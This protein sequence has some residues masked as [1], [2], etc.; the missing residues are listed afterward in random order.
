M[1]WSST[2]RIYATIEER[3][4]ATPTIILPPL[5]ANGQAYTDQ[6]RGMFLHWTF[7]TFTGT[8]F[9]DPTVWPLDTFSPTG[10]NIPQ[11]ASV[12]ANFGC[13][14]AVLTIKHLEG[15]CLWPTTTTTRGIANTTWYA[16]NGS[17]DIVQQYVTAFRAAG[18]LPFYYFTINDTAWVAAHPGWT[19]PQF[20]AYIQAQM[21]EV[22][23]RYGQ[24]G[25]I[26]LDSSYPAMGGWHPWA[27]AAER[28]TFIRSVS[29]GIIIIDN[30]YRENLSETDVISYESGGGGPSLPAGNTNPAE[31]SFSIGG[32]TQWFWKS[33]N[34]TIFDAGTIST[35]ITNA[36]SNNASCLINVPPNTSGV[37]PQQF[38]NRLDETRILMG[39]LPRKSPNNMTANNVPAP[40]VASASSEYVVGASHFEAYNSFNSAAD[41]FWSSNG[42]LPAYIQIDLGSAQLVSRYLIQARKGGTFGQWLAWTLAGSPNGSSWT[43]VSTIS[44]AAV[45]PGAVQFFDITPASYRY[46][47]W[48]I[49]STNTGTDADCGN[50][51]LI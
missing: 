35:A 36:N 50:L 37:I 51:A 25:A 9:V 12:A 2:A 5:L 7:A 44:Q 33:D 32:A 31:F 20:K 23:T 17:P 29:P 24:I 48:T 19:D 40:Y 1:N 4:V 34:E 47:R 11:W 3:S 38:I 10:L 13:R 16:A 27:S 8:E 43:T 14:Y 41:S 28:N 6:D 26:W 39:E 15:F 21:T 18:V 30:S 42:G 46:W 45:T 49:T 22:L